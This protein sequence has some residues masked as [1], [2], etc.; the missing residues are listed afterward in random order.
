MARDQQD[1]LRDTSQVRA[2]FEALSEADWRRALKLA[3]RFCKAGDT[4]SPEDLL[5]EA[6][7]RLLSGERGWPT[8][9]DTLGILLSAMRSI[10]SSWVNAKLRSP[11][12]HGVE[13]ASLDAAPADED[14]DGPPR[15]FAVDSATPEQIAIGAEL[16]AAVERSIEKDEEISL[17]CLAWAEGYVGKDAMQQVEMEAKTY[18][19]ARKRL[20]RALD[21]VI[22]EWNKQ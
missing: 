5:Q 1:G 17:V 19:A 4:W 15:A 21:G 7:A 11:I 14:D 10:A 12:D 6:V 22:E 2:A 13:V 8:S 18:D 3:R 16:F 9:L 20:M